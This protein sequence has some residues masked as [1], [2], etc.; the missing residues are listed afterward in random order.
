PKLFS[1]NMMADDTWKASAD[2]KFSMISAT[3]NTNNGH[4]YV[5]DGSSYSVHEIDPVTGGEQYG[6][7]ANTVAPMWDMAYSEMFSTE[8]EAKVVGVY[9][10]YIIGPTDPMA[11]E[12]YVFDMWIPLYYG[13]GADCFVAIT[14]YGDVE[15]IDDDAD[16]VCPGE[17]YLALDNVNH[18]WAIDI[19]E[20]PGTEGVYG[21]YYHWSNDPV[22]GLNEN[23]PLIGTDDIGASLI[24]GED[25]KA[26]LSACDGDTNNVYA[27]DVEFEDVHDDFEGDYTNIIGSAK[28]IGSAG[29]GV[30]PML[31]TKAEPVPVVT[32]TDEETGIVVSFYPKDGETEEDVELVVDTLEATDTSVSYVIH[33]VDE[34]GNV[35]EF[36]GEAEIAIP[37]PEGFDPNETFVFYKNADGTYTRIP[38]TVVPVN[39]YESGEN[40]GLARAAETE[41]EYY[42]VFTTDKF[43]TYV[44]STEEL[45]KVEPPVTE[46]TTAEDTTPEETTTSG[47]TTNDPDPNKPTGIVIAIVPAVVS[48]AAVMVT[49]RRNRK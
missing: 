9:A 6:V 25:G 7:A 46:D 21:S 37:V 48:A 40:S 14:K 38:A 17:R 3:Q 8:D 12:P 39:E 32:V 26:Y 13:T 30:W 4:I 45:D 43:G 11:I 24:M 47:D 18:L 23:Y 28:F 49:K 5:M 15:V 19:Y 10:E 31:L 42:L 29:D 35:V 27:I 41:G 16:E 33:V 44:L 2:L 20:M 34:D 1:W 36:V 22:A